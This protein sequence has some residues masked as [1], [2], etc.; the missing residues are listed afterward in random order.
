MTAVDRI[1][2]NAP[3]IWGSVRVGSNN[4]TN[5]SEFM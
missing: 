3:F 1:H 4:S 5:V 2:L